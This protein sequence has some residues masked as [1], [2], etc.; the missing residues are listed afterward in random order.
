MERKWLQLC[1]VIVILKSI[2]AW[3]QSLNE[4][5][6]DVDKKNP[7]I[8]AARSVLLQTYNEIPTAWTNLLP[9][10]SLSTSIGR[11]VTDDKYDHSSSRADTFTNTLSVSQDLFN[12]QFNEQF[13]T[14]KLNIEKQ[15]QTFRSVQQT[16]LMHVITAYLAVI[17]TQNIVKLKI[18]NVEVLRSHLDSTKAQHEMRRLTN[19][20][21]AQ[22]ESRLAQGKAD[23]LSSQVDYNSAVSTY[24]RLVGKEPKDLILPIFEN[25]FSENIQEI[26]K[27]AM[28]EH[29]DVL[30]A[31]IDVKKAKSDIRMKKR[32][33]GPSLS[34]SGSIA[35]T[36][37]NNKASAS[38][39]STV[40]SLGLTFTMPLYQKG[41]EYIELDTAERILKQTKAE[42]D[43]AM[44][45][46]VDNA[47]KAWESKQGASAKILAYRAQEKAAIVALKS[48]RLELKAGRRTV[49]NLLDSEK[50]LLNARV[51]LAGAEHDL[52]LTKYKLHERVGRLHLLTSQ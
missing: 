15:E 16:T 29:P 40:S 44:R 39:G 12:L 7:E 35:K 10:V 3:S 42:F 36:T 18:K 8:A 23:E 9:N 17:K 21:L 28:T 43:T 30:A 41:I 26:E 32:A 1:I 47:R 11:S 31:D 25:T 50:E 46:A 33:F 2:P 22:A 6:V 20:D 37:T 49:L 13:Q 52:I 19:A 38:T 34:L 14:A 48:L 24:R 27:M 51:N 45:L 4:V 5:I